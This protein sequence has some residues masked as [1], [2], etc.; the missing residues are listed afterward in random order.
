ML[1]LTD[2]LDQQMYDCA[3]DLRQIIESINAQKT[4][5]SS[6]DNVSKIAAI[7]SNHIDTINWVG[8]Q[9]NNLEHKVEELKRNISALTMMN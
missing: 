1:T 6:S 3:D 8:G 5:T 4:E 7:L 2:N 9:T